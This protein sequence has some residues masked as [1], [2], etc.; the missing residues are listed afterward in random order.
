M[1]LY[2]YWRSGAAYRLRIALNLKGV[3]YDPVPVNL[4][5]GEHREDAYRAVNPAG[6]V[7]AVELNDGQVLTQSL[8]ILDW[9]DR[10]FPQ[11]PLF[12][13]EPVA[14]AR[15]MSA[16]MAI[17]VDTHPLQNVSVMAYVRD[18]LGHGKSGAFTWQHHWMSRGFDAFEKLCDPDTRFAFGEAPGYAD[19]CLIPQVYNA[20][21][22]R[23]DLTPWPRIAALEAVCLAHPAFDAARPEN[24][25]DAEKEA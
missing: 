25:P 13:R 20:H 15:V 19:I 24:Q 18:D 6:L 1:K 7:P 12:P 23:L 8:A 17:A 14:R 10:A 3:P 11:P 4:L 21:R 22:W 5:K 9:L 2:T 16:G